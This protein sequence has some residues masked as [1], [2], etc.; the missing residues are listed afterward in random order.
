MHNPDPT[1]STNIP[2]GD[3]WIGPQVAA[4][5]AASAY[6]KGGLVVVVWDEDDGSGGLLQNVNDPVGIYVISPYARS[7]GY[8][9]TVKADHYSLLATFE[10]GLGLPRLGNA[11]T[12]TPLSDYFP[13]D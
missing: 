1:D 6:T 10:D 11:A 4:I 2:D 8:M 3:A 12:A 9:S 7:G 5:T 13:A